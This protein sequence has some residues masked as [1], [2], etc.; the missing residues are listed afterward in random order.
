MQASSSEAKSTP[1]L[2]QTQTSGTTGSTPSSQGAS[3]TTNQAGTDGG[4]SLCKP[5]G[6]LWEYFDSQKDLR[7][8]V[9]KQCK[10]VMRRRNDPKHLSS[11]A[12]RSHLLRRHS[13]MLPGTAA[14]TGP[15]GSGRKRRVGEAG[16]GK[17][18]GQMSTESVKRQATLHEVVPL[19]GSFLSQRA[20]G[21][22]Q[23]STTY[24]VGEMVAM[25]DLPL[26]FVE[27]SGFRHLMKHVAPWYEPP[28]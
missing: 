10:V 15:T 18:A 7:L 27:S 19:S 20:T 26:S 9:C 3:Q 1:P 16:R 2:P 25:S 28:S 21:K 22:A 24:V 14:G 8:A 11:S 13:G 12:L 17:E 23:E 6:S 4:S 5:R